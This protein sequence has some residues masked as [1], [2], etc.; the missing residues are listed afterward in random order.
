M[1]YLFLKIKLGLD[2]YTSQFIDSQSMKLI[3]VGQ[4][5]CPFKENQMMLFKCIIVYLQKMN[6]FGEI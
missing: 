4:A 6:G 5:N 2:I 3:L 1:V